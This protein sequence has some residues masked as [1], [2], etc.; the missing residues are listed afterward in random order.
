M[1][2]SF[3]TP[4]AA[5]ARLLW[6][7][8]ALALSLSPMAS[9]QVAG[10]DERAERYLD[11][12]M[13]NNE[14]ERLEKDGQLEEALRKFREASQIFD[15]L[16]KSHPGWETNMLG[17][18]RRKVEDSI[19]RVQAALQRPPQAVAMPAPA[20]APT[21]A[22]PPPGTEASRVTTPTGTTAS[23]PPSVG[24]WGGNDAP[25]N[26]GAGALE[27]PSLA[28]VFRQYEAQVKEKMDVLQR[29]NL[30]MEGALRK[31]DD[32]YRWASKEI[33]IAR[34]EK[35]GLAGK[36]TEMEKNL[37]AMQRE[38]EAGSASQEQLDTLLKE[39][40]ALL[41]L[42]KQNN[43]RLAAAE[44]K[45]AEAT[46]K[47]AETARQ[48]VEI[49][50]ERDRLKEERDAAVAEKE[51]AAQEKAKA[52]SQLAEMK[53]KSG[54]ADL[55][56]LSQENLR[57]KE[58]IAMARASMA[59]AESEDK[60]A[61][62]SLIAENELLRG[63]ILRQLR[64]QA[65]QQQV[66]ADVVEMVEKLAD[67][68]ANLM[69]KIREMDS[70][71]LTLTEAEEKLFTDSHLQ[72]VVKSGAGVVQATLMARGEDEEEAGTEATGGAAK[73]TSPDA[74]VTA[75]LL[76]AKAALEQKDYG[77]AVTSFQK[78]L[79][80]QPGNT[81]I[82]ISLGDAHLR[83]GQF[84][85]AEKVLTSCL[86]ATPQNA[87]AHHVLGMTYFREGKLDQATKA[88][89]DAAK[90]DPK[91]ALAHHYLGIIASRQKESERAE[92]EFRKALEINPLFGEAHF[93]LAVLY[94][95]ASPPQWD[96]ART[97]YE[98]ALGKG[99]QPDPNL[100]KL[101]KP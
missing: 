3:E 54:S 33:Q 42:E 25:G 45:S 56:K 71:R 73:A 88:F 100:E 43:E 10:V 76:Q 48:L 37:V 79:A 84:T 12:Y 96:K 81:E 53:E 27:M 66:R 60:E 98:S 46:G 49:T 89:E 36:L 55:E 38:V 101:L 67:A 34:G 47:L 29:R 63:V 30:E 85:E 17:T 8:I 97:E 20:S 87:A 80:G 15:G 18:R 41:A 24:S 16:A 9:A 7:V 28:D 86:A 94:A 65:K 6:L 35:E 69:D 11:G 50:A 75:A 68:P 44:A 78:A 57:L 22:T 4:H 13:M 59:E 99:V 52:E 21:P 70:A 2:M 32:W 93:N 91:Q 74:A 5:S 23:V 72:E 90:H 83:A 19:L 51:L 40:A 82:M 39:K 31:W 26:A 92:K 64:N 77:Q 95:S 62:A 61:S 1:N 14:G 58:E